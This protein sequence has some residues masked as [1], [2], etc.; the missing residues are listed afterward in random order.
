MTSGTKLVCTAAAL[1]A[2]C[3][4]AEMASA[5]IINNG[6]T[7][8]GRW[9]VDVRKAGNVSYA[10]LDPAGAVG[11]VDV[12]FNSAL[13]VDIGNNGNADRLSISTTSNVSLIGDRVVS[14]GSFAGENGTIAWTTESFISPGSGI[15]QTDV[16]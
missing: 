1:T 3:G 9:E 4:L 8:N 2:V 7:G 15:L 13:F 11:L 14:S 5:V 6:I 10:A 12:V 16:T